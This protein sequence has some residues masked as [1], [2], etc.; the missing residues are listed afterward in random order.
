MQSSLHSESNHL[1]STV[2]RFVNHAIDSADKSSRI[3]DA[4]P[5]SG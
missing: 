2:T 5:K 3:S 4:D 1:G